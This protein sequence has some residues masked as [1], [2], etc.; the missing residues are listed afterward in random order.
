MPLCFV[1]AETAI[2]LAQKQ[3]QSTELAAAAQ[4]QYLSQASAFKP[5]PQIRVP[6]CPQVKTAQ[7]VNRINMIGDTMGHQRMTEQLAA[8]IAATSKFE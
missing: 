6:I 4:G 5:V 3:L 1:P 8:Q 7:P 2:L